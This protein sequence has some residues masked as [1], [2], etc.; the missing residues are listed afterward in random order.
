MW[1]LAT[2]AEE[3]RD[4]VALLVGERVADVEALARQRGGPS[5]DGPLTM[6]TLLEAW[7]AWLAFLRRCD[8]EGVDEPGAWLGPTSRL[9]A[10][11]LYPRKLFCAGANYQD[12]MR[13]MGV[14]PPDK[15]ATRPFFFMKP[16]TTTVIGP[17]EPIR[18]PPG[19]INVDWEVELAVVIG[20]RA[21]NVLVADA[22]DYVAG[23][24]IVND[25]SARDLMR[26]SDWPAGPFGFD[27]LACKG[28]DTFAPMGPY[29]VPRDAVPDP[30]NLRL[31]LSVNGEVKQDSNTG[32]LIFNVEEQIAAL[33]RT[34]T[35]EPGDV[36]ATGT[37]AGVGA[38]RG[39]FLK[40]GD[41]VEAEI[42][43]IGTLRNP[44][45]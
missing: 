37:P 28:C 43:R 31:R 3:G 2:V 40:A 18:V 34:I 42:E 11:I 14:A 45:A 44:V 8:A 13:E 6:V 21:R 27:W 4:R 9:R 7:D 10:P 35:L 26:R 33:S 22:M 20:R 32:N 24:T 36:I 5:W 25:V 19:A 39:A 30:Y 41:L 17:E 16:P 23:F 38:P 15:A 12:H 1:K 29:L